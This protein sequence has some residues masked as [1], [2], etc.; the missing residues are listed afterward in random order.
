MSNEI[1]ITR[2]LSEVKHL[3]LRIEKLLINPTPSMV[4]VTKGLD[5]Q[6]SAAGNFVGVS[7]PALEKHL[8]SEY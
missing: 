3:G 7:I 6:N 2:A 1:S 4:A 8:K 5:A